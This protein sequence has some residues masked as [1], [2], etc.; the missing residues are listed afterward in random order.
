MPLVK[1]GKNQSQVAAESGVSRA[2]VE[3]DVAEAGAAGPRARREGDSSVALTRVAPDIKPR[4]VI[5]GLLFSR[6][7][8]ASCS[9][10]RFARRG[11]REG[12]TPILE[13]YYRHDR[14]T[15]V[16]ALSVSPQ[17][18]CLGQL[19]DILDQNL[20]AEDFDLFVTR[21]LCNIRGPVTLF[22]DRLGTHRS[23]VRS[24]QARYGPRL[25]VEWLPP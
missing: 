1:S 5:V 19:F 25:K 3:L 2:A 12:Q 16:S 7:N 21:L 13:C 9:S 24:L 20:T 18:R 11:L 8:R 23:A 17:R 10:P 6:M 14:L 4:F 22:S 15:V